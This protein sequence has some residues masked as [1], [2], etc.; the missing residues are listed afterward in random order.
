MLGVQGGLRFCNSN[1]LLGN[2]DL[3][4]LRTMI[5]PLPDHSP[6][7]PSPG[8]TPTSFAPGSIFLMTVRVAGVHATRTEV[9]PKEWQ[10]EGKLT[11]LR[12]AGMSRAAHETSDGVRW[13]G[14]GGHQQKRRDWTWRGGGCCLVGSGSPDTAK[15]Q[16]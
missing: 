7:D 13:G 12:Q 10:F 5:S 3:P 8:R 11:E 9:C 2:V 4:S 15:F 16:G 1:K 14:V 6:K